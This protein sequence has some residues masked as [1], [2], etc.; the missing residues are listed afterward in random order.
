MRIPSFGWDGFNNILFFYNGYLMK[1]IGGIMKNSVAK[2]VAFFG[3]ASAL[4]FVFLLIET[5]IF[6]AFFG[7]FTPA[8]L[9]LPLAITLS[10]LSDFKGS[11]IGGTIFGCC[12]FFLAVCI[13]NPVFINPLVSILPRVFIGIVAFCVSKL[14]SKLCKNLNNENLKQI[15]PASVGGAFGILTN[16]V[17]TIF[18]M[19]VFKASGLEAILTVIVSIN[20]VA[21]IIGAMILVPIYKRT[22][23]KIKI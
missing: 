6:T 23:N 15:I 14:V 7:S 16:S 4:M 11:L 21:E 17:L 1:P 19:W 8:V 20:F 3:V 13:A 18:M 10:L 5:E 22:L 9:T 12:S 2:K